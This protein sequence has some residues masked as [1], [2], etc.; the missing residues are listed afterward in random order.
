MRSKRPTWKDD[1]ARA[2]EAIL[3]GLMKNLAILFLV[4]A[5]PAQASPLALICTGKT[6]YKGGE[7]DMYPGTAVL[8]LDK[9]TFK[10]PWANDRAYSID[11]I[12]ETAISFRICRS[13]TEESQSIMGIWSTTCPD[14]ASSF[15]LGALLW[16]YQ[17]WEI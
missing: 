12:N 3:G 8:D 11:S 5:T 10:P 7:Y 9:R 2:D 16:S 4:L 13:S 1:M 14:M 6:L 17:D 15:H